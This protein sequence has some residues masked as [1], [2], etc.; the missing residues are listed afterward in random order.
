MIV[1]NWDKWQSFR[2]DR[3]APPWIKVHRNLFT[4]GE[5]VTL[6]DAEKGQLVSIWMLAADKGGH[7]PDDPRLIQRMAM[8]D[9]APDINRFAA[10]GFLEGASQ[11]DDNQ[12]TTNCQ[13]LDANL[14]H[15]SRSDQ[16]R[17]EQSIKPLVPSPKAPA[18]KKYPAL[19]EQFWLAYPAKR[20][21]SKP[22]ALENWKKVDQ[23]TAKALPELVANRRDN[24]ADWA[25]EDF[26][27][28][29]HAERY[30]L[31]ERWN[32]EWTTKGNKLH[33]QLID[34]SWYDKATTV[35]PF[36]IAGDS[37]LNHDA[38]RAENDVVSPPEKLLR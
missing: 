7:I 11:P 15:Q 23:E 13:P 38:R 24:C 35:N 28:V 30:L 3:G 18:K 19:F 8:L 27:Y 1:S 33:E 26:K 2:K 20:R 31:H 34:T 32:D 21:G 22:K 25:R 12:L 37:A 4:N 36:Q 17:G 10:L 5:W 6:T 14:T 16:I 9:D 29:P